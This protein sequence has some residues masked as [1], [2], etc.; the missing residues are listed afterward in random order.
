[1]KILI[2]E[3]DGETAEFVATGLKA[4]GHVTKIA[5]KR[6]KPRAMSRA[7]SATPPC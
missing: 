7:P 1:M 2:I 4:R 3:D 6:M 5:E